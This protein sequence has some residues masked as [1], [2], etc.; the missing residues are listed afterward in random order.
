MGTTDYADE[1]ERLLAEKDLY[2]ELNP[3]DEQ[4]KMFLFARWIA[5]CYADTHLDNKMK[6]EH[7]MGFKQSEAISVLNRE[8]GYWY[9]EQL[10]HFNDV[11]YPN[12]IKNGSVEDTKKFLSK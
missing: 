6:C 11:V 2:T 4:V 9:K 10:K 5:T 12:Y 8:T 3:I 7:D 1:G